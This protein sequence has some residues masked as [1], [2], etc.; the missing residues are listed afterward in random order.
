MAGQPDMAMQPDMTVQPG[1][2]VRRGIARRRSVSTRAAGFSPRGRA[3][4]TFSSSA[5]MSNAILSHSR[6]RLGYM[7]NGVCA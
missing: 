1:V 4:G 6:G 5:N 3:A 2:A 7:V